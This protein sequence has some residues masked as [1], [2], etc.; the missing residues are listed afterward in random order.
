MKTRK[1]G[2]QLI[3]WQKIF[4]EIVDT[5]A[6]KFCQ[7]RVVNNVHGSAF[8]HEKY[9]IDALKSICNYVLLLPRKKQAKKK[10]MEKL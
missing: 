8:S 5:K 7:R 2:T 3:H 4:N 9:K 10:K 6:T 1:E